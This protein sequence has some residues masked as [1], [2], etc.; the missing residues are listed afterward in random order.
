MTPY[1]KDC[2]HDTIGPTPQYTDQDIADMLT[3]IKN[4]MC[5]KTIDEI[6]EHELIEFLQS[7]KK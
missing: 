6:K 3:Y 2:D 4:A 5:V 7:K 1:H